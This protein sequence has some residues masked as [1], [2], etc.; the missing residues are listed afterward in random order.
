MTTALLYR[1][2]CDAEGRRPYKASPGIIEEITPTG[3]KWTCEAEVGAVTRSI[4]WNGR[5]VALVNPR[6]DI[7]DTTEGQIAMAMRALPVM[8]ATLR[9]IIVLAEKAEN[10]ELIQKVAESVIAFVEVEAPKIEEPEDA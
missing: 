5:E 2:F 3:G 7:D 9:A 1:A 6:G 4:M 8:D 10:L